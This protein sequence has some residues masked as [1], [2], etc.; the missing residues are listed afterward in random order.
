VSHE[1]RQLRLTYRALVNILKRAQVYNVRM[2][3]LVAD[4]H[5]TGKFAATASSVRND[6]AVAI[7]K[8]ACADLDPVDT[9]AL[10]WPAVK[11]TNY[12]ATPNRRP[13]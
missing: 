4:I 12:P 3:H 2:Q 9:A 8:L 6:I 13:S 5:P 7:L 10:D 1:E 11:A